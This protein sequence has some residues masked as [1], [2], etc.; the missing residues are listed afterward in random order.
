M[1]PYQPPPSPRCYASRTQL[2]R[3]ATCAPELLAVGSALM[4]P[5]AWVLAQV[6]LYVAAALGDTMVV[7]ARPAPPV[8]KPAAPVSANTVV[9]SVMRIESVPAPPPTTVA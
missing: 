1:W 6:I 2:M 5:P 4:A 3:V 7:R 8:V 9:P